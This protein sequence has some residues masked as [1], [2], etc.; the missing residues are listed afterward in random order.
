MDETLATIAIN[1]KG[2]WVQVGETIQQV[3]PAATVQLGDA[4]NNGNLVAA[5]NPSGTAGSL[6]VHAGQGTGGDGGT[7]RL[8]AGDS[9][10][11]N[12]GS[13]LASAGN[14]PVNGG[15][16][17]FV[18]GSGDTGGSVTLA[19]GLGVTNPGG[20]LIFAS[21]GSA[22][23]RPGNFLFVPGVGNAGAIP[24][25]FSVGGNASPIAI[26]LGEN[27]AATADGAIAIG[28]GANAPS[29]DSIAI[30]DVAA[31]LGFFSHAPSGQ[32]VGGA[33]TAGA[34]YTATEQGMIN[35][36]YAALRSYGLLT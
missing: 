28:K 9:T 6:T 11:G 17:D 31:L 13:W 20:D 33:A 23:A 1:Q 22:S 32:Q 25:I 21:G 19:G 18:A 8:S 24:A 14:G 4:N 27:A 15:V 35:R 10:T 26:A 16:F 12:G 34:A 29:A 30:G 3:D 2:P 36:M 5:D 7:L